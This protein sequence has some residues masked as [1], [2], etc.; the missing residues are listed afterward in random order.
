MEAQKFSEPEP[1]EPTR[2]VVIAAYAHFCAQHSL[3][4]GALL[5][6]RFALE[7]TESDARKYHGMRS[8]TLERVLIDAIRDSGDRSTAN[9]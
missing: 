6:K 1:D 7:V 8:A 9:T 4:P 5:A 2:K 3:R